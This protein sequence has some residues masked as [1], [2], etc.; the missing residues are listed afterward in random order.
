MTVIE[1]PRWCTEDLYS[2]LED[3]QFI[4][5]LK[6]VEENIKSLVADFDMLKI[7]QDGS[8]VEASHL[9]HIL[10]SI[11]QTLKQS[12]QVGH[13]IHALVSTDSRNVL[14]QQRLS[15]LNMAMLPYGALQARLTAWL[16][17]LT[18]E[19]LQDL[20]Q[21]S[22]V[23]CQ[24]EF[25][26]YKSMQLA[27]HQMSPAEEELSTHLHLSGAGAFSKLYS[28]Y[29][30]LLKGKYRGEQL[31]VTALRALAS[32]ADANV[33]KEAF[34]AEIAVWKESEMVC[35]AALNSVK[36]Q[37]ITLL[38]GRKFEKAVDPSLMN[39]NIDQQ[40]LKAMQGAVVR[41]LPDFRRYMKAKAKL[42]GKEKMDWWDL[43]A[44]VG[45]SKTHWTYEAGTRFVEEQ[46]RTY[47]DKLGDFAARAFK[48]NWID[49]GPREGKRGGAFCMGWTEDA[50]RIMMNHDPSLDS[51]STLAHE[52]G[53][54]YHN[55]ILAKRQ[56][57]QR[58]TPMTLAE[59][60]SIFCE[61]IIQNAALEKSV[62]EERLYVLET[63]L[64]G[65]T[66][67]VVDIYSRFLFEQAVCEKRAKRELSGQEFCELMTWAQREAYG[68]AL[69]TLHPY[70][71]AV[72]PHYYMATF[73]NY[74][75]T[76]GLLFGLGV[77]AQYQEA[78]QKGNVAEFQERYDQLLAHTGMADAH[79]LAL[80][81]GIDLHDSTF[82][83]GSLNVIRQQIDYYVAIANE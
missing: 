9:E 39:N 30:S 15:E 61:T 80:E 37:T 12:N 70:M 81:F 16:G 82:W 47:S 83:E 50:S 68:D 65:Q 11:N 55:F 54:G 73:Y 18:K 36:G 57:L 2:G 44:P 20:V 66:Q 52:L 23:I 27:K 45:Q 32:D 72:K 64:L 6:T 26:I 74:P 29:T 25:F 4:A 22:E 69:D 5:D 46:F 21:N 14:A 38:N 7:A 24:H 42:L 59:T 49:A 28:N 76:F 56:P 17:S 77:Y 13:F 33:R 71:W 58:K 62:D 35:A 31:P 78:C 79:K 41:A 3:P 67:V 19:E 40:T 51:V 60:A 63:Q 10:V 8:K 1:M 43:A 53:H 34:E 48:E 75:Y